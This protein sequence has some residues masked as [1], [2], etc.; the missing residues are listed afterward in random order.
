MRDHSPPRFDFKAKDVARPS[1]SYLGT[2]LQVHL[3]LA[4]N[5]NIL[6]TEQDLPAFWSGL[7]ELIAI[8]HFDATRWGHSP[9]SMYF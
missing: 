6:G 4:T 3:I 9:S 7:T 1:Q 8:L 5:L 2:A